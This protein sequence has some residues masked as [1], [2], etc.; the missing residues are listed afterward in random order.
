MEGG[1]MVA[2]AVERAGRAAEMV[3]MPSARIQRDLRTS[4]NVA[5]RLGSTVNI[6]WINEHTSIIFDKI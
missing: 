1:R 3:S 6:R 2:G 4:V 5:R